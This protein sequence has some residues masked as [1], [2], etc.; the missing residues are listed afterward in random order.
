MINHNSKTITFEHDPV[1][2]SRPVL[3]EVMQ[4]TSFVVHIYGLRFKHNF[5]FRVLPFFLLRDHGTG[6]DRGLV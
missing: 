1:L 5:K 6:A 2:F 3:D 4:A